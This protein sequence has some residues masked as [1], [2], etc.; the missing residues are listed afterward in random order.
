[1]AKQLTAQLSQLYRSKRIPEGFVP[2]GIVDEPAYLSSSP[3]IVFLLK[4]V[5]SQKKDP[6][7]S[8]PQAVRDQAKLELD[9]EASTNRIIWRTWYNAGV[10]ANA[11]H[12]GMPPYRDVS[13][14]ERSAEG[15]MTIGMTNVKKTRGGPTSSPSEVWQ[16]ARDNLPLWKRELEIM[17]PD[18]V[19]C[20]KLTFKIVEALLQFETTRTWSRL[21]FGE[22]SLSG[23]KTI[24][25]NT[26][27][28]LLRGINRESYYG[29]VRQA[30]KKLLPRIS[31]NRL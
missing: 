25:A 24:F 13:S 10:W 12:R 11:L 19:F 23:H 15:L 20:D 2:G 17:A 14:R 8:L 3:R 18:L 1:M 9:G 4:E 5:H 30:L 27:H 7:W 6:D 16:H 21:D 26:Y 31:A 22:M 29:D 28:P